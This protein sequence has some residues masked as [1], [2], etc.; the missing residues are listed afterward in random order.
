MIICSLVNDIPT[1]KEFS[2][3]IIHQYA[4]HWEDLGALLEL[5]PYKI[6]KIANIARDHHN[7]FV[8]A[9][10]EILMLWLQVD[11]SPTW[12]KLDAAIRSLVTTLAS[13]L[14]D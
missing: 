6:A 4:A 5:K 3:N 10:R 8:D 13:N 9:C 2:L 11:P 1:F 7:Q 14:S 12:G